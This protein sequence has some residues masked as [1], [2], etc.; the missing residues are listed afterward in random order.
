MSQRCKISVQHHLYSYLK[1]FDNILVQIKHKSVYYKRVTEKYNENKCTF[2]LAAIFFPYNFP[3][4]L[5][6]IQQ[7]Q[8]AELLNIVQHNSDTT[9]QLDIRCFTFS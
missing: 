7:E 8:Q 2:V 1:G 6:I 3:Q 5:L 4:N 9:C